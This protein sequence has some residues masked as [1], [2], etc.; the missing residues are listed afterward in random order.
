MLGHSEMGTLLT[1][2]HDAR[3]RRLPNIS[4]VPGHAE[5]ESPVV[6]TGLRAKLCPKPIL[7]DGDSG[8]TDLLTGLCGL[9]GPPWTG[10]SSL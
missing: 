2:F 9:L 5:I 3:R 8:A 6:T 7:Y 1:D 10:S 4:F